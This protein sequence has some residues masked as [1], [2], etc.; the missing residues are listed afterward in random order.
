VYAFTAPADMAVDISTCG[1]LF[2][3]Q[4]YLTDDPQDPQVQHSCCDAAAEE[5]SLGAGCGRPLLASCHTSCNC[6]KRALTVWLPAQFV[7]QA[8]SSA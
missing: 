7:Q 2:D 4:L 5:A 1:S 6:R 8:A 3:T